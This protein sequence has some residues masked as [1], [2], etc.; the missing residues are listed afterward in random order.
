MLHFGDTTSA[1]DKSMKSLPHCEHEKQKQKIPLEE[2]KE[3]PSRLQRLVNESLA[4]H[5][6]EILCPVTMMSQ[7]K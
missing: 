2:Q 7:E 4:F 3:N 1:I 6:L 5:L